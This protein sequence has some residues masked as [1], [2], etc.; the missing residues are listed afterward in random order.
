MQYHATVSR[1][2]SMLQADADAPKARTLA[3]DVCMRL[4][5]DIIWCRLKPGTA[6]RFEGLKEA[7][8]A[9][10]TTLREALTAL[11]ADGLVVSEGQKGFRVAPVTRADLIDLTDA[12]VLIERQLIRL[13]IEKGD[14]EWLVSAAAAF[15]RMSLVLQRHGDK[16]S[17]TPEWKRVHG[18]FHAALVAASGSPT[19]IEIRSKLYERAER[20]RTLSSLHGKRSDKAAEHKALLDTAM[21]RN[22]ERSQALI[23][24]H[25]RATTNVLLKS[26][27]RFED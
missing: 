19:L 2:F 11:V 1:R 17:S 10:F 6:L 26:D 4:R 3:A 20:Y 12:R 7:Y 23:D 8:G 9:S 15:H 5:D 16:A 18:R 24:K 27:V 14:D 25:I 13:A 21:A 22:V